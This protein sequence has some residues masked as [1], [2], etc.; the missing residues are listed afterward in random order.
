MTVRTPSHTV[1]IAG[2]R[3]ESP[4]SHPIHTPIFTLQN[5]SRDWL[6]PKEFIPERWLD[7]DDDRHSSSSQAPVATKQHDND[8]DQL[9]FS[10]RATVLGKLKIA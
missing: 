4:A 9:R 5:S 6:R 2:G 10:K 3:Y 1:S 7:D 8:I